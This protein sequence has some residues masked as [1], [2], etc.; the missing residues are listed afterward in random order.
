MR[1]P[2][3]YRLSD[4]EKDALPAEQA[5]LIE[6]MA[7]KTERRLDALVATP[8]AIRRHWGIENRNHHVRDVSC[9]EDKSRIR[10]NPG[11]MARARSFALNI[12]RT[13]GITNVAQALWNALNSP[14]PTAK[15]AD[16]RPRFIY[17]AFTK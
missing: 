17:I 2:V 15:P 6:R 7:A 3:R 10:D 16:H 4:T 11:I 12:L 13:N 14:G 1:L 5:A 9:D 8:A